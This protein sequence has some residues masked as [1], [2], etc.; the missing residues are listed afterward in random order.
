MQIFKLKSGIKHEC[1]NGQQ[2]KNGLNDHV[3]ISLQLI[4]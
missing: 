2:I 1:N 4:N 3:C